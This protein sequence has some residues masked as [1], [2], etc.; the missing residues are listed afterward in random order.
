[1]ALCTLIA[2]VYMS[3][4]HLLLN[5]QNETNTSYVRKNDVVL[6][7]CILAYVCFSSLGFL[8]VPWTLICELLPS[9]VGR[10]EKNKLRSFFQKYFQ[11]SILIC[12]LQV[13]GKI[14][15]FIVAIAYTL[16]FAVVKIFPYAMDYLGAQGIFY[17]FSANC[18]MA[19]C[20]I[21][22][23][24]PETLGKSLAEIEASFAKWNWKLI[25]NCF[26]C[27]CLIEGCVWI[28]IGIELE[29]VK[30]QLLPKYWN[31]EILFL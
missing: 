11:I 17:T 20:F 14:G 6:L 3:Y 19:V 18:F 22:A 31:E 9:E 7:I 27:A 25:V 26:V 15:G 5:E 12:L 4:I 29:C 24:L 8:V 16:M 1:M 10:S 13:K 21:Y 30:A 2:G 28:F 23:F